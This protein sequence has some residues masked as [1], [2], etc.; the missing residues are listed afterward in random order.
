MVSVDAGA[1]YA[2]A[3]CAAE[4]WMCRCREFRHCAVL[5]AVAVALAE[6]AACAVAAGNKISSEKLQNS[7]KNLTCFQMPAFLYCAD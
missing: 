4:A 6:S 7:Q 1:V 3:V 2:D 5:L